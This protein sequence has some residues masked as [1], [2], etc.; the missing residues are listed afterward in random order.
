MSY[1]CVHCS[2]TNDGNPWMKIQCSESPHSI[3]SY[4]CYRASEKN[5][6]RD[7]SRY[8]MNRQDFNYLFPI[9]PTTR[10]PSFR[11]LKHEDFL[12]MTEAEIDAYYEDM[13]S[14]TIDPIQLAVHE[15]QEREDMRTR[16]LEDETFSD[17][18]DDDY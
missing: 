6:P 8:V 4:L 15:E 11:L 2:Q 7:L 12:Q 13:E 16:E 9:T 1:T 18:T 14:S 10:E 5:Y 17:Q 3:C